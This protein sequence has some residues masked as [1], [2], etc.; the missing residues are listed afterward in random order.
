MQRTTRQKAHVLQ[1]RAY[2]RRK[3]PLQLATRR[4]QNA[5]NKREVTP[6]NTLVTCTQTP[7]EQHTPTYVTHRLHTTSVRSHPQTP[8]EHTQ[9][10]HLDRVTAAAEYE[11]LRLE[12][13]KTILLYTRAAVNL[14]LVTDPILVAG[15]TGLLLTQRAA[16]LR[17]QRQIAVCLAVQDPRPLK[18]RKRDAAL[19]DPDRWRSL[20][21]A[22]ALEIGH[23]PPPR[24]RWGSTI[25]WTLLLW[26]CLNNSWYP[27]LWL[28][29]SGLGAHTGTGVYAARR[30]P[31][32][33]ESITVYTGVDLAVLAVDHLDLFERFLATPEGD[34]VVRVGPRGRLSAWVDGRAGSSA[35]QFFND[36]RQESKTNV[37]CGTD[38][39]MRTTRPISLHA[40]MFYAYAG[41]Y[42]TGRS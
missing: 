18:K 2:V 17:L 20:T 26:R 30:C 4:T 6:P 19:S 37:E 3:T 40:E 31:R 38:R 1:Q 22:E 32:T 24:P 25:P 27:W 10:Y 35:A 14:L 9:K 36:A 5:A 15:L 29:P 23:S 28:G 39:V 8:T 33:G 12:E 11:N 7:H 16:A 13:T 34:A 21:E 41:N 42:W